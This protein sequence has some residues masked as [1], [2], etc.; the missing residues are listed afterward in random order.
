[1]PEP[2]TESDSISMERSCVGTCTSTPPPLRSEFDI[3]VTGP[4]RK[5]KKIQ[6]HGTEE[7]SDLSDDTE[8]VKSC[9]KK[10][11][12]RKPKTYDP[13]LDPW[14]HSSRAALLEEKEECEPCPERDIESQVLCRPPSLRKT[15]KLVETIGNGTLKAMEIDPRDQDK[16]DSV[17][18]AI[19]QNQAD[20][21]ELTHLRKQLLETKAN[22]LARRRDAG[23]GRGMDVHD[24][25]R[26]GGHRRN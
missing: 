6:I 9:P 15:G 10:P 21:K 11:R 24:C 7:D 23:R 1:M 2:E 14:V 22:D 16:L 18:A 17:D 19:V 4:E 3:S 20:L 5:K 8:P 26:R 12:T 13:V 25:D